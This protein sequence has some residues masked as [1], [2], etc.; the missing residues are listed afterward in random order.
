M[1]AFLPTPPTTINNNNNTNKKTKLEPGKFEYIQNRSN[2]EMLYTAYKAI[3][4]TENWEYVKT[5]Q[6][7]WIS[8][9][10]TNEIYQ[11]IE[12]QGYDGHSGCSFMCIMRDMQIIALEGEEKF[13]EKYEAYEK[14]ASTDR[15]IIERREIINQ[16]LSS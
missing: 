6:E 12:K 16:L 8:S 9:K 4:I 1:E 2:R 15:A 10:E 3:N 14:K 7:L 11:E 5:I 13:K